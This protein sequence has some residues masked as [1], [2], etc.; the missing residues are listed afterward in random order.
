MSDHRIQSPAWDPIAVIVLTVKAQFMYAIRHM[1]GR[2]CDKVRNRIYRLPSTVIRNVLDTAR[3][4]VYD[5]SRS[6]AMMVQG[7]AF[8]QSDP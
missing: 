6:E 3:R 5:K 7:L 8:R 4:S 2:W 1:G